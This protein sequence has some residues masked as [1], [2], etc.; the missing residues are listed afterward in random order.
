MVLKCQNDFRKS[1][2]PR[3]PGVLV[4]KLR[5]GTH[6]SAKLRFVRYSHSSYRQKWLR[7]VQSEFLDRVKSQIP[8]LNRMLRFY[9]SGV[10]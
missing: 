2:L 3:P 1:C 9:H 5:L 10:G 8:Q 4:P 7:A 6:L